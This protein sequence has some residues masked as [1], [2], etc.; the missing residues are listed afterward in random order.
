TPI[1]RWRRGRR[2]RRTDEQG[3]NPSKRRRPAGGGPRYRPAP[4][5]LQ[6]GALQGSWRALWAEG[7]GG[8]RR[9]PS[10]VSPRGSIVDGSPFTQTIQRLRPARVVRALA[11]H[12]HVVDMAF[13]QASVRDAHEFRFAVKLADRGSADVAH[14]GPQAAG[15]LVQ[16]VCHPALVRY[17]AVN[18]FGHNLQVVLDTLLKIAIGRPAP[19]GG[20]R[21]HPAVG[22]V[23]TAVKKESLAR[24]LVGAG[25]ERAPHGAI[26]A[27]R[28]RLSEV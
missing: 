16:H 10:A 12:R 24:R 19:Q 1:P 2:S 11:R 9:K 3:P 4:R 13:A 15:Q 17:L 28:D 7:W 20:A 22:F 6:T 26:G 27:R 5:W 25:E 18:P 8:R 21:P 14:G 23:G